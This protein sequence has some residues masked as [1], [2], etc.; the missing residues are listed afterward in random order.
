[1]LSASTASVDQQQHAA[2]CIT[3]R[4]QLWMVCATSLHTI[5]G[6]EHGHCRGTG[7]G[8]LLPYG[9]MMRRNT[10]TEPQTDTARGAQGLCMYL[11]RELTCSSMVQAA[12]WEG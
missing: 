7:F 9:D 5:T 1:M 6:G 3:E 2:C 12:K 10:C 4:H 11:L 8:R